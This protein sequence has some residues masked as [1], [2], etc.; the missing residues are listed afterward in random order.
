[1]SAPIQ[2][3]RKV[4]QLPSVKKLFCWQVFRTWLDRFSN[5]KIYIELYVKPIKL[6]SKERSGDSR[7][8]LTW[9]RRRPRLRSNNLCDNTRF[10]KKE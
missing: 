6:S 5:H 1:M 8:P 2:Q 9:E 7:V 4:L 3:R 10:L